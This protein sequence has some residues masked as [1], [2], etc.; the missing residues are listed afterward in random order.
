MHLNEACYASYDQL[1]TTWQFFPN[2][3][4]G[5]A[6][7]ARGGNIDVYN[8]TYTADNSNSVAASDEGGEAIVINIHNGTFAGNMYNHGGATG[9]PSTSHMWDNTKPSWGDKSL[10]RVQAMGPATYYGLKVMGA[11]RVNIEN[12]TFGGKNGGALVYGSGSAAN[13]RAVVKI[14][15]GVFNSGEYLNNGV[16]T[17]ADCFNASD[18]STIYFGALTKTEIASYTTYKERQDLIKMDAVNT[19]ISVTT[20]LPVK[21]E[22]IDINGASKKIVDTDIKVYVYYGTYNVGANPSGIGYISPEIAGADFY[23]YGYG[24]NVC[25]QSGVTWNSTYGRIYFENEGKHVDF[26]KTHRKVSADVGYYEEGVAPSEPTG[27]AIINEAVPNQTGTVP[28]GG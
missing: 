14:E 4:G 19:T 18:Y 25:S 10:Q 21:R 22:V 8:G 11:A 2:L 6:V 7:I 17:K 15:K 16:A 23:I 27:A 1:G 13:D 9:N 26:D 20:L 28:I 5:H 12:G 24:K 3:S